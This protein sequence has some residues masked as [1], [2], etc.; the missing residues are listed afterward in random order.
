MVDHPVD[1]NAEDLSNFFGGEKTL[2]F[3]NFPPSQ[4]FAS[5]AQGF[6]FE[7]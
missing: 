5:F 7:S 6:G 3:K 2:H 4:V 1:G